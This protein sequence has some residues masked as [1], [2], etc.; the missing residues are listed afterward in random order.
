MFGS[1]YA[2]QFGLPGFPY[3]APGAGLDPQGGMYGPSFSG[4]EQGQPVPGTPGAGSRPGLDTGTMV[5]GAGPTSVMSKPDAGAG[6]ANASV[7]ALTSGSPLAVPTAMDAAKQLTGGVDS[8]LTGVF[9]QLKLTGAGAPPSPGAGAPA[10][11]GR[12]V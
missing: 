7:A 3:T 9:D 1:D 5:A 2:K 10:T 6:P 8:G 11:G 4:L 12:G